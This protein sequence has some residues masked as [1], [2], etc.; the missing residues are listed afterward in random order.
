MLSNFIDK[1]LFFHIV[2][3]RVAFQTQSAMMMQTAIKEFNETL[4]K[5]SECA[6]GYAMYGQVCNFHTDFALLIEVRP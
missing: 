1:K 6:E 4:V 3:Y 2:E 5:F